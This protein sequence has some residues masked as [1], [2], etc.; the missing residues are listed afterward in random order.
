MQISSDRLNGRLKN[1]EAIRANQDPHALAITG[2]FLT[3]YSLHEAEK[4]QKRH[5]AKGKDK[6]KY[7]SSA[8]TMNTPYNVA[9]GGAISSNGVTVVNSSG[10]VVGSTVSGT[11]AN[12]TNS[13]NATNATNATNSTNAVNV[14]GTV[15]P[16]LINGTGTIHSGAIHC[17]GIGEFDGG[18]NVG[19]V[20]IVGSG[21][22]IAGSAITG[23]INNASSIHVTG[24]GQFDGSLYSGGVSTGSA[25]LNTTSV[26][27][28]GIGEFDGGINIPAPYTRLSGTYTTAMLA[29][30]FNNLYDAIT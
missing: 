25:G 9:I 3:G 15:D 4:A 22:T 1:M 13:T 11:V 20:T 26:H 18:L 27:A 28:T 10:Q 19:G 2:L 14:T 12:A 5:K 8:V 7:G 21:G 29:G 17:T 6:L 16:A 24:N 23:A 30:I